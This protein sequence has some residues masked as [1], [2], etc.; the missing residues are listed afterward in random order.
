MEPKRPTIIQSVLV[1]FAILVFV[2]LLSALLAA[3]KLP[4]W[5]FIF[6]VFALTTLAHLDRKSWVETLVGGLIGLVVGVSQVIGAQL[7]GATAGLLI[8]AV[9]VLVI[10]TLVVDGRFKYI[11]KTCLFVLTAVS[12]FAAFIPFESVLPIIVSF[13][14]G[15]AFFGVVIL[16]L[17]ATAKKK[18]AVGGAS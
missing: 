10:L 2:V 13:L 5:P 17:E 4:A 14:L 9:S 11:N 1:A 18:A 7:F 3:L 8:L 16:L 12:S 6:F 15:A